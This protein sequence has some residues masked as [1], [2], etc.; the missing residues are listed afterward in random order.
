MAILIKGSGMAK[1]KKGA[2]KWVTWVIFL[3]GIV[4]QACL[5]EAQKH[6]LLV[7]V[8]DYKAVKK[9]QGPK[10][11]LSA[12]RGFLLD[13]WQLPKQNLIEL[14]DADATKPNILKAFDQLVQNSHPGDSIFIYFSG[15]GTSAGDKNSRLPLPHTSGAFIPYGLDL[16]KRDKND[17]VAQ[18]I[19]GRT[20]LKPRLNQLDQ[21]GRLV[22]FAMDACF[23]GNTVRSISNQQNLP[24]RNANPF[25]E[26]SRNT[27]PGFGAGLGQFG[28]AS[29]QTLEPYP[30]SQVFYL[31]ASGEHETARDIRFEDLER[32][33][34]MDGKPHG[35]FTDALLR[36]LTG[37]VPADRDGD[38]TLTLGEIQSATRDV[39]RF[40]QYDHQP[41]GLPTLAED[42][43]HL[44]QR[45]FMKALDSAAPLAS[46]MQSMIAEGGKLRV[47]LHPSAI[48]FAAQLNTLEE[49]Q[50]S[51]SP[52]D[53][54]LLK[55][56]AGYRAESPAG[57]LIAALESRTDQVENFLRYQAWLKRLLQQL[58][59]RQPFT[60]NAELDGMG[61]ASTL[62][63]GQQL[64]LVA[65][66]SAPMY[67]L[68][69]DFEPNGMVNVIYPYKPSELATVPA[70]Q[71]LALP[72]L[73]KVKPPFGKD[74]LLLL[75]FVEKPA[76]LDGIMAK[77]IGF[78][79]MEARQLGQMLANS[80]GHMAYQ[81]REVFTLP[82]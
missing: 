75:G 82:E 51:Q 55:T 44:V 10:Y 77:S 66:S 47:K 65:Q 3:A 15:H 50:L 12:I 2:W 70:N 67:L 39:M 72:Q 5:A 9:L 73:A 38:G 64:G 25:S 28:Q 37:N 71:V 32:Y 74:T 63:Q 7:A 49:V 54:L 14:V 57:D 46:A 61:S 78:N 22:F 80:A 42:N 36:V 21:G 30:Y 68:V 69:L 26:V 19:V 27:G 24:A 16:R 13:T 79:S 8:G 20:D 60:L 35:A 48:S 52:F 59:S 41:Q 43:A 33:P 53:L 4:S 31:A 23:S 6:A 29:I 45:P 81:V 40:R 11:D 62:I 56:N 34:T 58:P 1:C 18:L 17:I 76:I